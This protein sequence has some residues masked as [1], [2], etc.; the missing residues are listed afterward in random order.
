MLH[1]G[2]GWGRG[3]LISRF[4]NLHL[5]PSTLAIDVLRF[6]IF[7]VKFVQRSERNANELKKTA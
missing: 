6:T 7:R 1:L 2:V 4:K 3:E 5:F